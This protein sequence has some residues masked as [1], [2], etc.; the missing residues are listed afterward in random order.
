VDR[1]HE[2]AI[3]AANESQYNPLQDYLN[4]LKWDGVS[5]VNDWLTKYGGAESNP[6]TQTVGRKTLI[7]AI[8]RAYV[9]GS[10]FDYVLVLEGAQGIGKSSLVASLGKSYYSDVFIDPS[11]KDS[12]TLLVGKWIVEISE[13]SSYKKADIDAMKRFITIQSDRIRMPYARFAQDIP[14]T[15]IFIGNINPDGGGYLRDT[16]GNRRFWPVAV[17][18]VDIEEFDKV[19]DQLWAEAVILFKQGEKPYIDDKTIN[20]YALRSAEKRRQVE[21]WSQIIKRNELDCVNAIDVYTVAIG[22]RMQDFGHVEQRRVHEAMT[23]N[24]YMHIDGVYLKGVV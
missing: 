15:C 20:E 19:V 16:T 17:S 22:G 6:Y 3:V 21:P 9:P 13:M 24:G 8:S 14:R 7:G 23:E 12:V 2:A 1:W 10:K 5:R 4:S 18:R 11:N